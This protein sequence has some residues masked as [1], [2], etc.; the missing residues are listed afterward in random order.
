MQSTF[1]CTAEN[2]LLKRIPDIL[3]VWLLFYL[4][5]TS[6]KAKTKKKINGKGI[7][8]DDLADSN[9]QLGK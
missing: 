7:L 5:V 8:Q 1:P 3:L 4:G 9:N 6:R 2:T